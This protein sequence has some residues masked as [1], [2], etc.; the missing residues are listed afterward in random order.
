MSELGCDTSPPQLFPALPACPHPVPLGGF[1]GRPHLKLL[2]QVKKSSG[3]PGALAWCCVHK[4]HC[5]DRSQH[6]PRWTCRRGG[7]HGEDDKGRAGGAPGVATCEQLLG[8]C[9]HL[10]PSALP[11]TGVIPGR[12]LQHTGKSFLHLPRP[13]SR[14][15]PRSLPPSFIY[16]TAISFQRKVASIVKWQKGLYE[17]KVFASTMEDLDFPMGDGG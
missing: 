6:P 11:L 12:E 5:G 17:N 15:P 14:P 8:M 13:R 1:A 2:L 3:C 7:A 16:G 9:V 4:A 10:G